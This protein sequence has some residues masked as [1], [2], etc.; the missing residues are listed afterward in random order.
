MG[1]VNAG[2]Q[3][4]KVIPIHFDVTAEVR[5]QA[6]DWNSRIRPRHR[7]DGSDCEL[8]HVRADLVG[9]FEVHLPVRPGRESQRSIFR[10]R[11]IMREL[12]LPKG[13]ELI[14]SRDVCVDGATLCCD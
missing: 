3:W 10:P 11:G 9:F 2:N 5:H 8:G 7:G 1:A 14:F 6:F 13:I 4:Y 12:Q